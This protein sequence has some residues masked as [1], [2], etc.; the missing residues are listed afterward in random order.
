MSTY[1]YIE[2]SVHIKNQEKLSNTLTNHQGNFL[3][4]IMTEEKYSC[5]NNTATMGITYITTKSN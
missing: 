4:N 1:F 3:Y 5:C 2:Q